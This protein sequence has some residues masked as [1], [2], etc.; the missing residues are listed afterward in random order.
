MVHSKRSHE[1]YLLIDH[2]NAPGNDAAEA[3]RAGVP[4]VPGGALFE[5]AT[6]TCAHCHAVVV[7]NPL[8]TRERGYCRRC[9]HYVCDKPEC[10]V[11][12]TPLRAMMDEARLK[13]LPLILKPQGG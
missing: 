5:S 10:S 12:C 13:E 2:R 8:R 6:I 4:F 7:L 3:A 9:D 1:G 11:D